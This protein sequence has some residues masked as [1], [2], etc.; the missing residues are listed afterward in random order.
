MLPMVN[1]PDVH[2]RWP[3]VAAILIF[4]YLA[5]SSLIGDSPTMDEPSHIGRGVAFVYTGNPQL[6]LDHPPLVNALSAL[7]L[8]TLSLDIPFDSPSWTD[9]HPA[10]IY[11]Y[12]FA[13]EL[14][15]QRGN[16]V[17]QIIFLARL[18]IVFMLL[19]LALV[20]FHFARQFW[21]HQAGRRAGAVVFLLLLFD[22]NLLA[23]GRYATT[24][25]GGTFFMFLATCLLWRMWSRSRRERLRPFWAWRHWLLAALGMGLAFGSK[26]SILTFVPI[27]LALALLPQ[28]ET[29]WQW[30]LAIRRALQLL[31]A[32]LF[33]IGVVWLTFGLEWGS[34]YFSSERL[35]FLNQ[36]SGPMPT[37][38]AGIE[39]TLIITSG[40][41]PSFLLGETSFDGFLLYFPVAFLVKTPL[42]T[43]LLLGLGTAVLLSQP[44]H[45]RRAL[46]LLLPILAY[47]VLSLTS[48]LNIGYR[49]LFPI[50]PFVYLLISGLANY[51]LRITNYDMRMGNSVLLVGGA[52]LL[53]NALTIHPHY[54]SFFNVVGGGPTQG[55]NILVDSNVD[56]GQDLLRLQDWLV[57]NGETD[58]N[59]G[60]FG[61]ADPAYYAI[62]H[63]PIPGFPRQPY[64][65]LWVEPP[66][67]PAQPDPGLYAISVSNLWEMHLAEK[68][69]YSWFRQREPDD[70]IGYSIFIYDLR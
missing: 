22:P 57:E 45:R 18:P 30:R 2:F 50:L 1:W 56:W 53:L 60:W 3:A 33:S 13:E 41:R 35:L 64:Y 11:W 32:G 49:H 66:F 20:G 44:S 34:F 58:V 37:F 9:R 65:G 46:W 42:P 59:L 62:P 8:L 51:E 14:L 5:L 69:V 16:N 6:S 38:W 21:G 26:L 61:T 17:T 19:G 23:H 4:F 29:D 27:W 47:F 48:A 68:N 31:T 43:L 10:G 52:W 24:D 70:R 40:G 67:N 39:K 55:H 7:P 63:Q 28:S 54:L 12:R 36:W 15:W 25:L